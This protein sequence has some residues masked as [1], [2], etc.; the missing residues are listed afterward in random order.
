M[1]RIS[2]VICIHGFWSHGAGMVLI[3]RYLEKEYGFDV[4]LYSYP[5]VTETLDRNAERL[6][7]HILDN[8]LED[9][10]IVAH[11]LGGVVSLRMLARGNVK[12]GG[13]LACLGSPLSGSRAAR[14]LADRGD[15][16][17]P[18]L[19]KSLPAGTL[20][21]VANDWAQDV[22]RQYD[23]GVLAGSIPLGIGKLTGAFDEPNDGTVAVSETRLDGAKDHIIL[24]V[25]HMG[26]LISSRAADQAAAF[27]RRGE[28]LR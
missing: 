6:E 25:S 24:P 10:H 21:S 14:F 23:V 22:C 2:R 11:S 9:S 5:S 12:I 16:I 19:G 8:N 17:A 4:E 28:F 18:I 27:I 1:T 3:K 13:R 26:M 15:W 7:Q 20:D